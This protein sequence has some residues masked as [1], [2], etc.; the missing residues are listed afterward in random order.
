MAVSGFSLYSALSAV[1]KDTNNR[2]WQQ[3]KSIQILQW[4]E[5]LI[6]DDEVTQFIDYL[7]LYDPVAK[8]NMVEL[9]RSILYFWSLLRWQHKKL[10]QLYAATTSCS[11][12]SS[13]APVKEQMHRRVVFILFHSFSSLLAAAVAILLGDQLK[14]WAL[15]RTV[16]LKAFQWSQKTDSHN[17]TQDPVI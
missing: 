15:Q 6:T 13:I 7:P 12:W 9:D 17:T 4:S 2:F 14:D 11:C 3:R 10:I 8:V 5:E 16:T 1:S